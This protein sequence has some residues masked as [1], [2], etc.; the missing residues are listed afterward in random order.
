MFIL[1]QAPRP[2]WPAHNSSKAKSVPKEFIWASAT[3]G[4]S[5]FGSRSVFQWEKDRKI[6][7]RGKERDKAKPKPTNKPKK[8]PQRNQTIYR[9]ACHLIRERYRQGFS[10]A[11][12][13][14]AFSY[15]RRAHW[16]LSYQTPGPNSA[17][18]SVLQMPDCCLHGGTWWQRC[19]WSEEWGKHLN[20]RRA[21]KR[22]ICTVPPIS[23]ASEVGQEGR[24]A[25][26]RA[27]QRK[28]TIPKPWRSLNTT[29][30][31]N[32]P[33]FS[34]GYQESRVIHQRTT[35]PFSALNEGQ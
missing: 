12:Q 22:Y 21:V 27:S 31:R 14:P 26:F 34:K 11:G 24:T 29:K 28:K 35:F 19:L 13:H 9:T 15:S 32:Y 30:S 16:Q 20:Y 6:S 2:V 10:C 23:Q 25:S 1:P 7:N 18:G 3:V 4:C 17:R 33:T 8:D 5:R